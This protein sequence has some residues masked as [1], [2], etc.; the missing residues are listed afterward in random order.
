[1]LWFRRF[2]HRPSPVVIA[3][4]NLQRDIN[5][6]SEQLDNLTAAVASIEAEDDKIIAL[7]VSVKAALDAAIAAGND[8]DALK[9]LSDRLNAEVAKVQAAEASSAPVAPAA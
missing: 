8:G 2:V 1:M 5:H 3:L 6:M 4:L 9:A 7:L